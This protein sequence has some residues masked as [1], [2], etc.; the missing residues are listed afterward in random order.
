MEMLPKLRRFALGLARNLQDADDLL[1]SAVL[2]ALDRGM[3]EETVERL[4]GWM[5]TTIRNI[6]IDEHR[7]RKVRGYP[8]DIDTIHDVPG[9][10]G[11]AL[12][13]ARSELQVVQQ[14]FDALSPELRSAAVLVIL[15][16]LSY[17]E[18]ASQ[19]DIPIGTVMSRVAR[20]RQA[21]LDARTLARKPKETLQ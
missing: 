10:D 17:K 5:Y 18:A 2:R 12:V 13:E 15:N 20:S 6:W 21:F 3:P 8:E 11:T 1:Q 7:K 4:E 19:L 14:A 16:G 9:E